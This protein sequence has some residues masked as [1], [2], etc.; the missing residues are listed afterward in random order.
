MSFSKFKKSELQNMFSVKGGALI[1][2]KTST[3]TMRTVETTNDTDSNSGIEG[4]TTASV[5]E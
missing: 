5:I 3:T 2:N 4:K 1:G